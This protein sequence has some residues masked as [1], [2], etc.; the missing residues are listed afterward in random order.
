MSSILGTILF[1]AVFVGLLV[2]AIIADRKRVNQDWATLEDLEKRYTQLN[3]LEEVMEFHME[4]T[5]K[6][7]KIHNQYIRPRL[8]HIDGYLRGQYKALSKK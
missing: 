3:T 5:E 1:I 4:F 8:D 7:N 2:W 6:A